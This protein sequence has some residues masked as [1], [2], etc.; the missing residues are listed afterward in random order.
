MARHPAVGVDLDDLAVGSDRLVEVAPANEVVTY[1]EP[2]Q[3][4]GGHELAYDAVLSDRVVDLSLYVEQAG[5][6]E[7]GHREVG[8]DFE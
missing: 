2:R 6:R 1:S 8:L 3:R 5:E 4:M 7:V